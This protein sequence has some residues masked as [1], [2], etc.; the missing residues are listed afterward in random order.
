MNKVSYSIMLNKQHFFLLFAGLGVCSEC[1]DQAN[2]NRAEWES[3]LPQTK[4]PGQAYT[5]VEKSR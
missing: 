2:Q 4:I 1:V 3:C 5:T